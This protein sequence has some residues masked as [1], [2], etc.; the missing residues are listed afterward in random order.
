M[1]ESSDVQIILVMLKYVLYSFLYNRISVRLG[2]Q[3][4]SKPIDCIV[5]SDG[6]RSCANPP[7]VLGIEST[8]VYPEYNRPFARHD[9]ALIRMPQEITYSGMWTASP[10]SRFIV[11][12][13]NIPFIRLQIPSN[14]FAYQPERMFESYRCLGLLW[15]AGVRQRTKRIRTF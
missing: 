14:R 3:D 5:Y 9:I 11:M 15:P 10:N 8:V 6:A 12:L 2:E 13:L 4:K 1:I 7:I